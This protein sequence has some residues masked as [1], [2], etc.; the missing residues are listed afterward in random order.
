MVWEF[1]T[2][3]RPEQCDSDGGCMEACPDEVIRMGWIPLEA[4]PSVG[5]WT[6]EPQPDRLQANWLE[7]LFG[8]T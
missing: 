6:D 3:A 1:A 8:K 4:D 7:R 2:L 5:R